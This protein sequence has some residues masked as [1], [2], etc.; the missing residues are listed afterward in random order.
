ME[1]RRSFRT[2]ALGLI[3]G[4]AL[5]AGACSQAAHADDFSLGVAIPGASLYLG[6]ATRYYYAPP[7]VVAPPPRPVYYVAPPA[8]AYYVVPEGRRWKRHGPPPWA[9]RWHHEKH[10]EHWDDD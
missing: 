1:A 4:G 6:Q 9:G 2:A 5:L 8:P 7:V 10:W 3:L